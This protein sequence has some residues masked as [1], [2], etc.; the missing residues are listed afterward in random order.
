MNNYLRINPNDLSKIFWDKIL[1]NS[2]S[3][4][5]V[6]EKEFYN[7]IDQ[8]DDLRHQLN[9]PATNTGSI[10]STTAWLLFSLTFFFKP[11]VIVEIGSFIGKSIFSM[12]YASDL[13]FKEYKT[14]IFC[15]DYSNKIIFPK[16]TK[17]L[18][19]QF[20]LTS[21]TKMLN[22]IE[23]KF[24]IDLL[25]VDGRLQDADFSLLANKLSN[26]CIVVLDDF[27]GMEKGT[28]NLINIFSNRLLSRKTHL[29]IYPIQDETKSKFSLH[30]KSTSAV[31]LPASK[32]LFTAQ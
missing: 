1:S 21:S 28:M 22:E 6:I 27:E 11:K 25:H 13:Y 30:E 20:H 26:E 7:N 15:C 24:K 32:V 2:I 14:Q 23:D 12:A 29:L 10:T 4:K 5:V 3:K 8:L 18:I 31:L 19:Q 16:I 17:N 9:H